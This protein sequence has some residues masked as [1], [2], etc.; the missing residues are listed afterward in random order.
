M[1]TARAASA[2]APSESGDW[3]RLR[4]SCCPRA[5]PTCQARRGA[6][7]AHPT[8]TRVVVCEDRTFRLRT[9]TRTRTGTA[10]AA[11]ASECAGRGIRGRRMGL[12]GLEARAGVGD[13]RSRIRVPLASRAHS[14]LDADGAH[15]MRRCTRGGRR[16]GRRLRRRRWQRG[17][18]W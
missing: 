12:R 6:R 8:T 7:P 18:A 5:H 9:R 16:V 1:Q 14:A 4:A 2:R 13:A 11:S 17:R 10:S 3:P 15:R